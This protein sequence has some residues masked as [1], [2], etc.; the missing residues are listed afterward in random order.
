ML[1]HKILLKYD[2]L[3]K[4]KKIFCPSRLP[5]KVLFSSAW[6]WRYYQKSMN[7]LYINVDRI[8]KNLQ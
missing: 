2:C 1:S 7:F 4:P 8:E 5:R 6:Y 3:L